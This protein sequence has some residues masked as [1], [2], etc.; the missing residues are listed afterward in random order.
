MCK[1][2]TILLISTLMVFSLTGCSNNEDSG[3]K[4]E[5]NTTITID[6]NKTVDNVDS[7]VENITDSIINSITFN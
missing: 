6:V 4:V 5:G 3:I 7:F 1:K 2:I